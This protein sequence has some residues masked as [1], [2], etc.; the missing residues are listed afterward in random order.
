MQQSQ[1]GNI[2]L[3]VYGI[4]GGRPR[5]FL[6]THGLFESDSLSV[7]PITIQQLLASANSRFEFSFVVVPRGDGRMRSIDLNSNLILNDDE[8]RTS[9]SITGRVVD[10]NGVGISGVSLTLS[11]SQGAVTTTDA[12]GTYVFNFIAVDGTHTVTPSKSGLSFTPQNR[13][14][15]NPSGNKSATFT[16]SPTA[17]ASDLSAFFVFQH[18]N[19]FLNRDPDTAG[20]NFWTGEIENCSPKP[21]CTEVKRINVSAAFFLSIE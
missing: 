14:F 9:V 13:T 18:Y 6:F 19:D 2:D 11:G 16:T 3:V 4:Y 8:P 10:A 15:A 5:G 1:A 17:N 7:P 12:A 20:L 21:Q